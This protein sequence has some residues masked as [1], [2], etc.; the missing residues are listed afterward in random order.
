[1][2]M[3]GLAKQSRHIMY[4]EAQLVSFGNYLLSRYKVMEYSTDGTNTPIFQRQVHDA[5]FCNW[6]D[7]N[8]FKEQGGTQLPSRF[9]QGD[10][11]KFVCMPDDPEITTFPSIPC[12]VLAVH[13][14]PGKVKYDLDLLFVEDQRS[15]IY[16]VDSVLVLPA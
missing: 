3:Q 5:D 7:A 10:R 16:N 2:E 9:Q 15:R 13:F 11:A 1:M 14:Y 12:E 8:P 6:K 4:T